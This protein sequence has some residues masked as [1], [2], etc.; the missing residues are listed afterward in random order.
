MKKPVLFRMGRSMGR[1]GTFSRSLASKGFQGDSGSLRLRQ[2]YGG[3]TPQVLGLAGFLFFRLPA[4]AGDRSV[5]VA[6]RAFRGVAG[7]SGVQNDRA[8]LVPPRGARRNRR[9][10]GA[11][12]MTVLARKRCETRPHR[13]AT[14]AILPGI[15][16]GRGSLR[17]CGPL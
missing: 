6:S 10:V 11:T 15:A 3:E 9:T 13:R 12:F 16:V 8:V 4:Y 14:G 5:R 1:E 2:S 17:V 7:T